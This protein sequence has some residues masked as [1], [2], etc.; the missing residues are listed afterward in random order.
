MRTSDRARLLAVLAILGAGAMAPLRAGDA[1]GEGAVSLLFPSSR[2]AFRAGIQEYNSG[3]KAGA[4]R[5]LG[6]AAQQG[7]AMAS[8]KLARMYAAGDG[9]P[10][11]RLKAFEHYSRI[12][13]AHADEPPDSPNARFVASAFVALG[14]TFA[15]GIP[16]SPVKADGA[17]AREM[18]LYAASYFGDPD[19]Q[20][21]LARLLLDG[22][23]GPKD[24]RQAARWL[25]LAADKG[26]PPAQ[27]VL[28]HM[29]ASGGG[30][31]KQPARGLALL[32]LAKGAAEP[33]HEGWIGDLHADALRAAG[34]REREGARALL[35]RQAAT[36][37]AGESAAR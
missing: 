21:H 37:R 5:A 3:D 14:S 19:A 26:H 9:V 23:G 34:E 31:P 2:D 16:N 4:A 8:W 7:H 13:D 30:V 1:A 22:V 35:A 29:L 25:N 32:S 33:E 17:R 6:F 10:R 24:P 36:V 11:D 15:E 27:A 20:Y 12:A 28:G 18:F